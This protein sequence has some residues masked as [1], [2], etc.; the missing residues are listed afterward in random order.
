MGH[1]SPRPLP[2][3]LLEPLRALIAE[4]HPLA[5]LARFGGMTVQ[6]LSRAAT[7]AT[8]TPSSHAAAVTGV[9]RLIAWNRRLTEPA[10]RLRLVTEGPQR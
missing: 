9:Q 5:M 2:G 3:D 1:R 6:V 8:L 10:P 7:G 4:G